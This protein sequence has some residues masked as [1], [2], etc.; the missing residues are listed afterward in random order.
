[1]DIAAST[2]PAPVTTNELEAQLDW[3]RASPADRGRLELIVCRPSA[4]KREVLPE[5]MLDLEAGLVGDNWST[6]PSTSSR[7]GG[8]N[9]DR[10]VTLM[11]SRIASL[12]SRSP[13]RMALAGDQLYVDFDLS[14]DNLPAGTR[15]AVGTAVVEL[16]EPW[17]WEKFVA[18]FGPDAMRFVNSPMARQLRRRGANAKVVTPGTVPVGDRVQKVS[19][20]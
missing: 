13:E 15:L 3:L 2:D 18:R 17:G 4:D 20:T 5:G 12:V 10:Q 8:P 16:N 9:P 1:V 14:V 19:H 11:N 7:D 6:K